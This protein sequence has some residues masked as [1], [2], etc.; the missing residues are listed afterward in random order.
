M[1]QLQVLADRVNVQGTELYAAE[2]DAPN[3][4]QY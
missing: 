2:G 3:M 1:Q 4:L